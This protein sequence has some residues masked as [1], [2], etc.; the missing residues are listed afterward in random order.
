MLARSNSTA[1]F[2]PPATDRYKS[3]TY[4]TSLLIAHRLHF[5]YRRPRP[6]QS[7]SADWALFLEE[8]RDRR[9][10]S[11]CKNYNNHFERQI[12]I[13]SRI[14]VCFVIGIESPPESKCLSQ[15]RAS[16]A[17]SSC[18]R[19]HGVSHKFEHRRRNRV[20]SAGIGTPK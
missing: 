5:P 12:R 10:I 6:P 3:R 17:K 9:R 4:S 7:S 13:Y 16:S 1:I 11:A 18:H 14:A 19:N 20:A 8:E 2:F 15:F